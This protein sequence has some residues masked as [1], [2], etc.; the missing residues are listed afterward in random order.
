MEQGSW[1]ELK[2]GAYL[3]AAA[4]VL[5]LP[6]WFFVSLVIA[7]SVH[8]FCHYLALKVADVRIHRI[9][10]GPFGASMETEA[11]G[12]GRELLCALAGPL[13][14]LILVPCFRWMPGIALCGLIQGSVNLLPIYP[15]DGGRILRCLL[16][17]LRIPQQDKICN[18][19]EWMTVLGILPLGF[20]GK[21]N[22]N[23]GWGG[24]LIGAILLLRIIRRKIPCKES[25]FGVQ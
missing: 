22:W 23:L 10:I 18:A 1:I 25:R 6:L 9:T 11:M 3:A 12:P 14:S 8:E 16:E 15:M 19:A 5:V 17:L 20:W 24:V 21:W 7:A 13:G 4:A 2:A